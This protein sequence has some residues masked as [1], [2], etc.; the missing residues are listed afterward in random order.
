MRYL[1]IPPPPSLSLYVRSFWVLEGEA[2][3][4]TPYI[5]RS[6]ADGCPELICHYKGRFNEITP[7][8]T[9][10]SPL[11]HLHGQSQHYRRFITTEDFSIFGVYL[12]PFAIPLL[13]GIP[14]YETSNQAPDWETLVS[15][16]NRF[17]EEQ[18]MLA[19]TNQQRL[20]LLSNFLQQ[21]LSKQFLPHPGIL[22]SI[23][24]VLF[25]T[26]TRN[27]SLLADTYSLS[28]RQFERRFKEYSGFSPK[29]YTRIARFQNVLKEYGNRQ[30]LTD[31]ALRCGYYD[32]S[33]FIRDFKAF[34]GH[35]PKTYFAGNAEGSEYMDLAV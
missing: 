13:F 23:K 34:S 22:T 10:S 1:T 33:H 28:V 24:Q 27:V 20:Q 12:Y 18:M 29:L 35:N 6:Y 17:F 30:P 21:R 25:D 4:Q 2:S 15:N 11:F 31:I 5:Y 3:A 8:G 32:Q 9:V 14:T 26:E 16:D 7:N 19:E